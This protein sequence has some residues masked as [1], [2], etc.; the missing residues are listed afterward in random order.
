MCSLQG[1]EQEL[2]FEL[3][4]EVPLQRMPTQERQRQLLESEVMADYLEAYCATADERKKRKDNFFKYQLD[5][6]AEEYTYWLGES[7]SERQVTNHEEAVARLTL[8]EIDL[9]DENKT[10]YANRDDGMVLPAWHAHST[11]ML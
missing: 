5:T 2:A 8:A 10:V 6:P 1:G 7:A 3:I 11:C 4:A 9:S